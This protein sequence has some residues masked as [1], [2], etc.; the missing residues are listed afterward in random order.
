MGEWTFFSNYGHVLVCL[1]SNNKARLRDVA[2]AVGITERAVQKIVK[3]LEQ[4][5]YVTI[6]KQGRCN[7]YRINRRK[8]LRHG[9][10]SHVTVSRLLALIAPAGRAAAAVDPTESVE[11]AIE[12]VDVVASSESPSAGEPVET[13]D[14]P[15]RIPVTAPEPEAGREQIPTAPTSAKAVPEPDPEPEPKP[16]RE[17]KAKGKSK[18]PSKE[19][20]PLDVKQQGSLF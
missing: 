10:E 13:V 7:R 4:A 12:T 2:E 8:A 1:A 15:K 9:L 11:D 5:G 3:D 17:Q 14:Q 19:N 6:R 16:K 20:G 18:K